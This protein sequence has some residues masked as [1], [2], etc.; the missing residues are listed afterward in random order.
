MTDIDKK[1][2]RSLNGPFEDQTFVSV[3]G[4]RLSSW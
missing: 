2:I 1:F 3:T 4:F